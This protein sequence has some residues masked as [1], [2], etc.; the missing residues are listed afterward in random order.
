MKTPRSFLGLML[1]AMVG[2]AAIATPDLRA[3]SRVG[4]GLSV[5]VPL[6]RG[7]MEV[8]V[9][10]EH[11]YSHRGVFYRRGPHGFVVVQAPRGAILRQLP[12]HCARVYVNQVVYY[13]YG[14]VY[15]RAVPQGYVVV[16]PPAVV[17][18]PPP[19]PAD[20]Y[21]SVWVGN[22]EFLF[23]DGQFFRK[24]PEGLVWTEAPVGAIAQALPTDATSVWYQG[25]EYFECDN[26]YFRKTPEGYRVVPVPWKS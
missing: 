22:Q 10:R 6:P 16:D 15:Y 11:F 18:A 2:V 25:I 9:G 20:E 17:P 5:G 26:V 19:V 14:G 23:K 7:Y 13:R 24:T 1:A 3:D 4:I 8:V 12:P 21:Q